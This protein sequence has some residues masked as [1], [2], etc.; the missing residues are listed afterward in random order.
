M[1]TT[2]E[3]GAGALLE[4]FHAAAEDIEVHPEVADETVDRLFET[5]G[6]VF[7][8]DEVTDPGHGVAGEKAEENIDRVHRY[9]ETDE[10]EN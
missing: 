9:Q 4:Y 5:G 2:R 1:E 3:A 7:F 8:E 6:A 10:E